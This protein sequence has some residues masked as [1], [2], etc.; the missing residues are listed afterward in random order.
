MQ[1]H[2]VVKLRKHWLGVGGVIILA[3]LIAVGI[4]YLRQDEEEVWE[5]PP[6]LIL[7]E[8]VT[9]AEVPNSAGL[10]ARG[11]VLYEIHCAACHGI[12]GDGQGPGLLFLDTSPRDFTQPVYKFRTTRQEG[13][14]ADLDLFRTITTGFP[15]Y[16]MPSFRHLSEKDRWALV[17]RVKSFFPNWTRFGRPEVITI[18]A[19]PPEQTA[20]LA[21]GKQ[22]YETKYKCSDC[23]GLSGHGDGPRAEEL[24]DQWERPISPRDFTI[25]PAFLKMGWRRRDTVRMLVTGI[26]GTPM[27]SQ[28]DQ[29][30]DP[31]DLSEFWD[32]AR[33]VEQLRVNRSRTN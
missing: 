19:E 30:A 7:W 21:R 5:G 17:H 29:L 6:G 9:A 10:L 12:R 16:G 18:T 15:A 24:K 23:H 25:G 8:T 31:T 14:P 33:Y 11:R 20:S 28:V 32:I 3:L 2:P 26:P 27:P 13:M 4:T 1:L 22:L